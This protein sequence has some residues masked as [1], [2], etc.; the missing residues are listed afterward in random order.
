M[1]PCTSF[2]RALLCSAIAMSPQFP[3]QAQAAPFPRPKYLGDPATLGQNIQRTMTLL[4][5]STPMQ[6]N[7]VRILFYGQSITEQSWSKLVADDLKRRFPHANLVIENRALGGFSSQLLVKTA[8]SD[9]YSFAPDLVIFHVYGAHDSYERIIRRIRERTTS[10]VLIQTDHATRDTDQAEETDPAKIR[11]EGAMWNS[12]M[13]YVHLPNVARKYNVGLVDQR[14]G[15]K[16]YLRD[17][18]A[19][20]KSLLSD[21]VHLN[22]WGSFLMAEFARAQLV[23]RPEV[24]IDP[25]NCDTVRTL[26]PAAANTITLPFDGNRIDVIFKPGATALARAD[27]RIDGKKPSEI[28]E[29]YSFTR[30]LSTPGGKWPVILK[31][32]SQQAPIVEDWTMQAKKDPANDKRWTFSLSGSKTGA[33]GEGASDQRF[34]SKSGRI[35]IDA[36]DWNVDYSLALPGIKPTPGALTIQWSAVPHFLDEVAVPAQPDASIENAVTLAHGLAN[37]RHTLEIS[38]A[39][40]AS[41]AAI[42]VYKPPFQVQPERP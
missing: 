13:N 5:T 9:L 1:T 8:E 24:Q 15:W 21:D 4:A 10:E 14:N 40:S 20:A 27:V 16:R 25:M 28:G 11:V 19:P 38:G 12:F 35:V 30:A 42:R 34:V 6:R 32:G 29:L 22:D 18:N 3:A 36:E 26:V 37:T 41:I 33:D 2:L 31:I 39:A 7:T 23:R 17:T